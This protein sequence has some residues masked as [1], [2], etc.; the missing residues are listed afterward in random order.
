MRRLGVFNNVS[1]DGYF[2]DPRG[3]MRW[4]YQEK[5]DSEWNAFVANNASGDAQLLFGR[6]TYELMANYWPTPQAMQNMPAVAE[7]MNK[8]PKIV[9]SRT[10]DKVTWANTTLFKSD[11]AEQDSSRWDSQ[12]IFEAEE[13]L[14]RASAQGSIGRYQLEAALQSAHVY[15]CRTGQPNWSEILKLYGALLALTAS[16]V[17]AIN[18]AL[19][20]AELHGPS[21]G[22]AA[23]PDPGT[24]ARLAEYQPYW[25][26]RAE[27]LTKSGAS[28]EAHQTYEMAIGLERD[29][30]V[31]RFLQTRQSA[32]AK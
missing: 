19:A 16:P 18:R 14:R 26:A 23:M 7:G 1:L 30:A 28:E 3:D 29:P 31:R 4:A 12:M 21:A 5:P 10:L 20:L 22:L 13:L 32:L 2:V 27:L 15:R 8:M 6:I 24:D 11:L 9:F 17:V 25:A